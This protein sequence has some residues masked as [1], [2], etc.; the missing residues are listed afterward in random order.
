[1]LYNAFIFCVSQAF[2]ALEKKIITGLENK[3]KT[4]LHV[5]GMIR[6]I[7]VF[8]HLAEVGIAHS[9]QIRQLDWKRKDVHAHVN[10][11]AAG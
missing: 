5:F 11:K 3:I 6:S 9:V 8:I 7:E 10:S 1:L 4:G 2:V